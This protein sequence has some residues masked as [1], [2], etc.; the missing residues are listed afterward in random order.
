M[1]R[2]FVLLIFRL[3]IAAQLGGCGANNSG[4]ACVGPGGCATTQPT[5]R[6]TETSALALG[7]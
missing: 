7:R 2:G 4:E 5:K 1:G 3:C 6:E